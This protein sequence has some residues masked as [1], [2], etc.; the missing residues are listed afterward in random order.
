MYR[1]EAEEKL[2]DINTVSF[3]YMETGDRS[4]IIAGYRRASSDIIELAN[5]NRDDDFSALERLKHISKT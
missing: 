1:I 3:P 5:D 2:S 4:K